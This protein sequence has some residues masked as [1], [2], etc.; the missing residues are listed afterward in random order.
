MSESAPAR[1]VYVLISLVLVVGT[2][3]LVYWFECKISG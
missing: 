2:A 3:L 1:W